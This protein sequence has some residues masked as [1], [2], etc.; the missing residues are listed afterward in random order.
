MIDS[1]LSHALIF[2]LALLAVGVPL[3]ACAVMVVAK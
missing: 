1:V 2:L 3:M